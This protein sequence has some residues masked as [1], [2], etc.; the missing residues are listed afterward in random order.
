[1]DFLLLRKINCVASVINIKEPIISNG[2]VYEN[3][4]LGKIINIPEIKKIIRDIFGTDKLKNCP[5]A[6]EIKLRNPKATTII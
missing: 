1:M 2:N 5:L 3:I 4:L 6:A